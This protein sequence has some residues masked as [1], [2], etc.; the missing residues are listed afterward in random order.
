MHNPT[1]QKSTAATYVGIHMWDG[2]WCYNPCLCTLFAT[3]IPTSP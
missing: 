3:A 2:A 1:L